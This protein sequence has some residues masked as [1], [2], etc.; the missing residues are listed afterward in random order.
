M[1]R[2][3]RVCKGAHRMANEKPTDN[4][5]TDDSETA[6]R[7]AALH[8]R[9]QKDS[10]DHTTAAKSRNTDTTLRLDNETDTLYDDGLELENDNGPLTGVGGKDDSV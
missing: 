5:K 4:V 1:L 2:G 3:E 10:V 7:G 8:G 6:L 9:E